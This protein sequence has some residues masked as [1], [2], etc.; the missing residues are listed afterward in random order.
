[1]LSNKMLFISPLVLVILTTCF[2]NDKRV[3]P[4][5][6]EVVT[7]GDNIEKYESYFDFETGKVIKKHPS[8]AWQLG[9]ECGISGWHILVNSGAQWLIYNTEQ[10]QIGSITT[11]SL[12]ADWKY[13]IQSD[14]PDSTAVGNWVVKDGSFNNYT[15]NVYLLGKYSGSGYVDIFQLVFLEVNDSLYRF[16]YKE[17]GNGNSDTITITKADS[18]N[19]VYYSFVDK[20]QI[21]L[22]PDKSSYDIM[23]G[24]YYDLA[25]EFGVTIP[26]LV[27][28]VLINVY[29][30]TA[31]L[32][33]TYTYYQ[34]DFASLGY[35]NFLNQ[36]DIIGYR[37]KEVNVNVA[38]GNAAYSIKS[39]YTY[40]IHSAQG[41]YFKMHFLSYEL[42]GSSGYPQ[43]EYLQLKP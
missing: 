10:H 26:Y 23:F 13:D 28:G 12:T 3:A 20:Q 11:P 41:N 5:P 32:D 8:D 31:V 25:T 14:Y 6:G 38:G 33:S 37:W 42:S 16:Y 27:R 7:I 2:E 18:V 34:I 40:I 15:N 17:T 30:T 22:E 36:R 43:F 9:F 19:F 39:N 1:M 35:M 4:Y 24:P 29:K 21:Q